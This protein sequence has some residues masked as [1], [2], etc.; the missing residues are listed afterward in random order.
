LPAAFHLRDEGKD[1]IKSIKEVL[2]IAKKSS[3]SLQISH[4]KSEKGSACRMDEVLFMIERARKDGVDIN[5]DVYP[6]TLS[7]TSLSS[8]LPHSFFEGGK[9]EMLN[10]LSKPFERNRLKNLMG[11]VDWLCV[12]PVWGRFDG[13][14]SIMDISR[15]QRVEP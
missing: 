7:Y 1:L 6:F 11:N 13:S 12:M 8:L 14:R 3:V 10:R 9:S 5:F 4:L 15:M 2:R